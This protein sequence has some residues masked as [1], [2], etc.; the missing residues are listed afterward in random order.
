M[1]MQVFRVSWPRIAMT[2]AWRQ[3]GNPKE[4]ECPPL[5]AVTR[6]MVKTQ[7]TENLVCA[8]GNCRVFEI[9]IVLQ[10]LVVMSC[11]CPINPLTNTNPIY[12]HTH[13]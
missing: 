2:E 3:F 13:T 7:L 6:G 9:A 8:V 5:E 1:R 4:R 11:K 12:S 10:V